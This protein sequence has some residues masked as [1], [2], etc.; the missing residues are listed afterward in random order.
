MIFRV[1]RVA[2]QR[3]ISHAPR[4]DSERPL[5]PQLVAFMEADKTHGRVNRHTSSKRRH[6]ADGGT[7]Q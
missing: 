4:H 3:H 6:Q 5:E 2:S 1:F 7:I